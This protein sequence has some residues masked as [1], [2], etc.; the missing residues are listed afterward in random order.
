MRLR[1]AAGRE[2][3][4]LPLVACKGPR[5]WPPPREGEK[6]SRPVEAPACLQAHRPYAF[7]T[8]S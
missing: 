2:H 3:C 5:L 8:L 1:P 7:L 6:R 4:L